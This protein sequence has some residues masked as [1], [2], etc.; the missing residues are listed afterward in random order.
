MVGKS[1]PP[2]EESEHTKG[3]EFFLVPSHPSKSGSIHHVRRTSLIG[4]R[5]GD[6]WDR[7]EGTEQRS[8]KISIYVKIQRK[9]I[10]L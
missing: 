2:H 1:T 7:M 4:Y 6:R 3:E 10:K 8:N 9:T 5:L